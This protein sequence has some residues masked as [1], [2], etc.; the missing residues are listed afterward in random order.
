MKINRR[1]FLKITGFTGV[2]A[3]SAGILQKSVFAS[4]SK[5]QHIEWENNLEK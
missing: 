1:D 5:R 3:L 4:Y 2:G